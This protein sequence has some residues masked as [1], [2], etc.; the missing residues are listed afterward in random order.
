MKTIET[1][2]LIL[3]AWTM[4]D[5]PEMFEYAKS[6]LVGPSAGWEPHQTID[7]TKQYLA[8]AIK[9]NE[10]WAITRK[11]EG[12]VIGSIGLHL[13]RVD[14]VRELGYVLH[15]DFWEQGIMTE[16]AKAVIDFGFSELHLDAVRVFHKVNNA[17][18]RRVIQK[19]GFRYDGTI[20][21]SS[22][23]ADG[24]LIDRCTYSI[25]RKEW[26]AGLQES[27]FCGFVQNR[28]C[29]YFPCHKT[30]DP[31]HFNCLFCYCPLYRME[32]CGG[33]PSY[34]PNGIKDCSNCTVPHFHYTHVLKKLMEG[35]KA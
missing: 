8:V 16:A 32:N 35:E 5:A 20:R 34:L 1:E 12:C 27:R 26:E 28:A 22:K 33:N 18:S 4:E 31:E 23:S 29:E 11:L 19:C 2:R 30:N 3:R 17:R 25:T 9:E 21:C 24:T 6:P 15:P 10:T 13:T 14:T 7:D